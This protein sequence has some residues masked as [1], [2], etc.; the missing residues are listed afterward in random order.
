MYRAVINEAATPTDLHTYIDHATLVRLW[1]GRW[2]PI[3]VRQ[4]WE[5]RFPELAT[6]RH[7]SVA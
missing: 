7:N 4:T 5:G 3:A 2:L 6:L 1:P